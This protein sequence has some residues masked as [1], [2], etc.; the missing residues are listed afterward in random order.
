MRQALHIFKKDVRHLRF[1]IQVELAVIVGFAFTAARRTENSRTLAWTLVLALLPL[2]WWALIARLIHDEPLPGDR[3]FWI[4]RPYSWKSLLGAKALFILAFINLPML[5]ADAVII[6]AYGL[7]DGANLG[8]LLWSQVL[9]TVL[10]LFP[11]AALSALTD[12][13]V[14]LIFAIL[15]PC[16][17]ALVIAMAA[18]AA[19]LGGFLGPFEWVKSYWVFLVI[20]VVVPAILVWQYARRGTPVG[21]VLAVGAAIVVLVGI[22]LI[23]WSAAFG[24]ESLLSK[25]RVDASSVQV[26]FDAS[27]STDSPHAIVQGSGQ[28]LVVLPIRISGLASGI[29]TRLE[30]FSIRL[31]A[32]DGT[33]VQQDP[34]PIS[35][36]DEFSQYFSL[37]T[38]VDGAFYR[39]VKNEPLKVRGAAY[40]TLFGHGETTRVPFGNSTV[41]VPRVGACSATQGANQRS[42]L[43]ICTSA[44]RY[45]PLLM[46]Y[47]FMGSVDNQPAEAWPVAPHRLISY[48]PFPAEAG[49]DPVSQDIVMPPITP[50]LLSEA[51]VYTAE[52]LAYIRRDFEIANLKLG[53]I[54]AH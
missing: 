52:P 27:G 24:V 11:M 40:L 10:F 21:R 8:G 37:Q 48:S 18:P 38:R 30:A 6:H 35:S 14:Q 31:E 17:V 23:P 13:F 43:M 32:P 7:P 47:R 39:K 54:G 29:G 5:V 26:D 34:G 53:E 36:R 28:V 16:V 42:A 15:T 41:S 46:S 9:L 44:F 33:T 50:M 3:Q 19:F 1:D 20:A 25:P 12:G 2:T 45:P 4:T 49:I 22:M 51:S